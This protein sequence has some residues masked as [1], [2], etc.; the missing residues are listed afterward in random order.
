MCRKSID[1][2]QWEKDQLIGENVLKGEA[3]RLSDHLEDVEVRSDSGL[4]M[5]QKKT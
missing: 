3:G 5:R 2:R 4:W 1:D